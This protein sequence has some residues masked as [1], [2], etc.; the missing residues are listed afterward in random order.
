MVS[1]SSKYMGIPIETPIVLGASNL[2]L[3]PNIIM[4]AVA[5][6]VGAVVY[7]TLFEEVALIGSATDIQKRK[8][9]GNI[10]G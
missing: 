1:L 9:S 7:P 5:N 10:L 6:G 4:D 2:P 3:S 8:G